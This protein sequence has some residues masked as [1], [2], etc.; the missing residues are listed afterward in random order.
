MCVLRDAQARRRGRRR[1]DA[2]GEAVS[3]RRFSV[4][5]RESRRAAAGA[6]TGPD[7]VRGDAGAGQTSSQEVRVLRDVDAGLRVPKILDYGAMAG[8][9]YAATSAENVRAA[10]DELIALCGGVA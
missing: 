3:C 5:L 10:E 4:H 1:A 2:G 8:L 9:D 7:L 6:D